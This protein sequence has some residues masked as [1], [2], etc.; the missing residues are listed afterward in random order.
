MGSKRC[1]IIR[2]VAAAYMC[3]KCSGGGANCPAGVKASA[4]RVPTAANQRMALAAMALD[5]RNVLA[6]G[7]DRLVVDQTRANYAAAIAAAEA[8]VLADNP[9]ATPADVAIGWEDFGACPWRADGGPGG[10]YSHTHF[11]RN[12]LMALGMAP[13]Y[14]LGGRLLS[15]RVWRGGNAPVPIA[16]DY[17]MNPDLATL[18]LALIAIIAL[19]L[20]FWGGK[21]DV[22][23][24]TNAD[25]TIATLNVR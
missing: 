1:E 14:P 24:H 22:S 19:I 6:T 12:D 10:P 5:P 21:D 8:A 13:T 25:Q 3:G 20:T 15:G 16:V 23:S 7:V 2:G 4:C 11:E 18:A 9:G 17:A